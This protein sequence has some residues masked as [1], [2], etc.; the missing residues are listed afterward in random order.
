MVRNTKTHGHH[1]YD[2]DQPTDTINITD[3]QVNMG[4]IDILSQGLWTGSA[5]LRTFD[6]AEYDS[7][8]VPST[9]SDFQSQNKFKK[10]QKF[11]TKLFSADI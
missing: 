9:A 4:P 6:T 2:R 5:L 1:R 3:I 8:I 7:A 11:F 10:K